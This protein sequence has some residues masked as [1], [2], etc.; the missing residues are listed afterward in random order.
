VSDFR[1]QVSADSV[2]AVLDQVFD[3]AKY[4]WRERP[5]PWR[6][7][8]QVFGELVARLAQLHAA[9]PVVYYALLIGLVVLLAAIVAHLTYLTWSAFRSRESRADEGAEVQRVVHDAA[10]H[11][12]RALE[13][14][15][16][17]RYAESLA[18]RF[19]ALIAVL[20][21]RQVIRAHP[22]KTPAEYLGEARL[23]AAGRQA[24][25]GVVGWLYDHLFGG[26]PLDP[27][28]LSDFDRRAREV[29]EHGIA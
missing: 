23:D 3:A 1:A 14:E 9:H 27:A 16:A 12:K 5:D 6:W 13:L 21:R 11:Q 2:R 26:H 8:R 29:A 20:D 22:S 10:W 17:G 19:A 4:E 18:H 28:L 15:A 7:L 25:A 24:L